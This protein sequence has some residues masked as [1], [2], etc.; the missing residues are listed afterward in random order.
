MSE[1]LIAEIII[2]I[3]HEHRENLLLKANINYMSSSLNITMPYQE[4]FLKYPFNSLD[5][6]YLVEANLELMD[7]NKRLKKEKIKL[8]EVFAEKGYN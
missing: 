7:E 5:L 2:A 4:K 1:Q 6:N 8:S 3:D